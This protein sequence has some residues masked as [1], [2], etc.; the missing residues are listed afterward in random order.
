MGK[1]VP[2]HW[3]T[4]SEKPKSIFIAEADYIGL[5]LYKPTLCNDWSEDA[6]RN[7]FVKRTGYRLNVNHEL[8]NPYWRMF[9]AWIFSDYITENPQAH[10]ND[11]FLRF[12]FEADLILNVFYDEF[13]KSHF[14]NDSIKDK[15]Q[16]FVC[17]NIKVY[18]SWKRFREC[19]EV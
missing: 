15:I 11:S 1:A 5:P 8:V 10:P 3:I 16:T 17:N 13:Q 6:Q 4:P 9:K 18:E 14:G 2:A 12:I 7:T 19:Q